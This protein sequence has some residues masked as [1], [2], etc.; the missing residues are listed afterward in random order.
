M[1]ISTSPMKL[2]HRTRSHFL[3]PVLAA[4]LTLSVTAVAA[5]LKET[6]FFKGPPSTETIEKWNRKSGTRSYR[7]SLEDPASLELE[8]L[9]NLKRFDSLEIGVSQ[10]PMP[11]EAAAWKK[12]AA[13][14]AQLNLLVG[15]LPSPEALQFIDSLGF[16]KLLFVI[17]SP[18]DPSLAS[19]LSGLKSKATITY[20]TRAYPRYMD[21]ESWDGIP[22]EI[23]LTI[24]TDYWPFYTQMDM[25]NLMKMQQ[26]LRVKDMFPP[27]DSF[28]Y[29][30][31]LKKLQ[32]LVVDTE[33]DPSDSSIWK[34]FGNLKLRWNRRGPVPG[35]EAL[36]A[37]V[38][39]APAQSGLRSL[40][41]DTDVDL[42]PSDRTRLEQ[43]PVEVQWLHEEF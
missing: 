43:L 10:F 4:T 8:T 7:F 38:E 27:E 1:V 6:V 41:L 32:N 25:L 2:H 31:N 30:L 39:S 37:F 5:P 34:K 17:T 9:A 18:P 3:I 14:G 13:R 33:S 19:R 24:S 29:L 36:Q 26:N 22:A 42:M 12:L 40:T 20:A 16:Q 21:R 15:Y 35:K 23:P 11:A 28:P